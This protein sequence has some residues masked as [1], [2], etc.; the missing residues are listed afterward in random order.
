MISVETEK[1]IRN[2]IHK[3]ETCREICIKANVCRRTYC[4]IKA[5]PRMRDRTNCRPDLGEM[6]PIGKEKKI[7]ELLERGLTVS[8]ISRTLHTKRDTIR[9]IKKLPELR[10]R[11]SPV[12]IRRFAFKHSNKTPRDEGRN[13]VCYDTLG[14][15]SEKY[16]VE[17]PSS[18][19]LTCG[20]LIVVSPCILCSLNIASKER[21]EGLY[22]VPQWRVTTHCFRALS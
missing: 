4:R 2:L 17:K 1:F 15:S 16:V 7:R 10:K 21:Q 5:A 3:G 18:R 20:G 8:V 14:R 6:I 13:S 11:K 9:K 12:D 19:C 22:Q